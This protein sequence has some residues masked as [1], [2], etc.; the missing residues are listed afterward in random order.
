MRLAYLWVA[1]TGKLRREP[2]VQASV[3]TADG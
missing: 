1:T 2:K 3:A